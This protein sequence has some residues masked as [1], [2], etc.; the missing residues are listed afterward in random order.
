MQFLEQ[1]FIPETMTSHEELPVVHKLSPKIPEFWPNS[2]KLWLAQCK[3]QFRTSKITSSQT[4]FDLIIQ[5]INEAAAN[6]VQDLVNNPPA[7]NPF[8]V[9]EERLTTRFEKSLYE[10]LVFF[11]SLPPLGDRRPSELADSIL[12]ALSG[13][14]H[15]SSTCPHV[16]HAFLSRMPEAVRVP[17]VDDKF[18]DIQQLAVKADKIWASIDKSSSVCSVDEVISADSQLVAAVQDV[19]RRPPPPPQQPRRRPLQQQQQQ[20]Q[21]PRD[22][23]RHLCFYHRR[24]RNKAS[25]CE[26]PCDWVLSGNGN[27]GGRRN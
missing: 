21:R 7:V 6:R 16:F 23:S 3:A 20:Q 10:R 15:D 17:L 5:N 25:Y 8:E 11:N 19:R 4:K 24:F 26:A 27:A 13:I 22:S 2:V 1:Q 12:A 9:L 18:E 14:G